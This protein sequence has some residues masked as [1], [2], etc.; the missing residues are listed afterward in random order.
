MLPGSESAR[1]GILVRT[2]TAIAYPV[3]ER[4]SKR[5]YNLSC[6]I[7][8][9]RL[10][11]DRLGQTGTGRTIEGSSESIRVE[12]DQPLVMGEPVEILIDWPAMLN[13]SVPM[14][15]AIGGCVMRVDGPVAAVS[16]ERFEFRTRALRTPATA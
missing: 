9:R 13:G 5:R 2:E 6:Q 8:Y 10:Y 1:I 11:G 12:T 14:L 15:L 3:Q 4:R 7:R 16:V